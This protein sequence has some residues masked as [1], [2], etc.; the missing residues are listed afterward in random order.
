M[1]VSRTESLP[2]PPGIINSIKAGFD[3]V[4]AHITAII[5]PLALNLFLWLGPRLQLDG[6]V[7]S[8]KPD[9]IAGWQRLNVPQE[10]IEKMVEQ[11]ATLPNVNL[12]ALLRTF[13]I[14]ISSLPFS[15][16]FSSFITS[17]AVY[18]TAIFLNEYSISI[19]E[20]P[21]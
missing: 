21:L 16:F 3:A 17:S 7:N 1:E 13:P 4:A 15:F 11:L 19:A 5:F 6:L 2:P 12:F 18:P 20:T 9:L 8:L 14:G 10:N